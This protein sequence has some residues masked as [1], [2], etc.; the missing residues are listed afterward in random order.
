[1]WCRI[2][3]RER[4]GGCVFPLTL[5][6]PIGA[7]RRAGV[8]L[9]AQYARALVGACGR[10]ADG[11]AGLGARPV[12]ALAV[13]PRLLPPSASGSAAQRLSRLQPL[14]RRSLPASQSSDLSHGWQFQPAVVKQAESACLCNHA[15]LQCSVVVVPS[16][17][18]E[19]RKTVEFANCSPCRKRP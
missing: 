10:G 6:L 1:M 7:C 11:R 9:C 3:K 5:S 15:L 16:A 4:Q 12:G 2:R 17:P 8:P 14:G 18:Q 19:E 13:E